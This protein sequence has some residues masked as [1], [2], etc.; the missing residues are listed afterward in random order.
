MREFRLILDNAGLFDLGCSDGVFT[1]CNRQEAPHT[2]LER[3]NRV[4]GNDNWQLQFPHTQVKHLSAIYS[5]VPVL[6]ELSPV[7]SQDERF[8]QPFRFEA[9]W[10]KYADSEK[11]IA[12][13]WS[14]IGWFSPHD[15]FLR[16]IEAYQS[17][18]LAKKSLG[19]GWIKRDIGKIIKKIEHL[20]KQTITETRTT[21][22]N[23]KAKL[24]DLYHAEEI[25]WKQWENLIGLKKGI[26]TR[27]SFM[28]MPTKSSIGIKSN[29]LKIRMGGGL[30]R[31]RI[32]LS[33][34]RIT[35]GGFLDR[36]NLHSMTWTVEWKHYRVKSTWT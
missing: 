7:T 9:S 31:N 35:L 23:L 28:P 22:N 1:W 36:P 8:V 19:C 34:S 25:L 6:V 2:I 26:G 24:E 5:H 18:L 16:N 10:I 30:I 13:S 15:Q 11:I 3:L 4:C 32:L 20:R 14:C 27:V 33:I 29:V 17:K 21:E 12:K